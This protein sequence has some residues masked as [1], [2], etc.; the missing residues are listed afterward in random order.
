MDLHLV[1]FTNKRKL[2][3]PPT[4]ST[5]AGLAGNVGNT[6]GTG[7]AARFSTIYGTVTDTNG[8]I[9]VAEIYNG[10]TYYIRKVTPSGVVTT[11]STASGLI[12]GICIDSSNNIYFTLGNNSICKITPSGT[13]TTIISSLSARGICIDS[14]SNLYAVSYTQQVIYKVTQAGVATIFAGSSGT[15]GHSDGTGTNASFRYPQGICIGPDNNF[16]IADTGNYSIRKMTSSGVVT[17]IAGIY[18]DSGSVDGTGSA[19]RFTGPAALVLDASLNIYVADYYYIS[20]IRKVT[21]AGV[22]TTYAGSTDGYGDGTAASAQF[23]GAY[24]ICISPDYT[25]LY[26]GDQGN[27]VIRKIV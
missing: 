26:I 22:V 27:N 11:F 13:L 3:K 5:L 2:I 23:S 19:A 20:K 25:T 9:F 14:S 17:T 18:S 24:S 1:S 8:N 4:V 16:Y 15:T 21:Q 10:T 6:N 7:S 12:Q